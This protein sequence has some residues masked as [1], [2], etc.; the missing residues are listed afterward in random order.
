MHYF[1]DEILSKFADKLSLLFPIINKSEKNVL[2][3]LKL[4]LRW[5][6]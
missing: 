2:D 5:D 4:N 1:T 3:N 6:N